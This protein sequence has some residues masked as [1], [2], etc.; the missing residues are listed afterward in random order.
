MSNINLDEMR[1][2]MVYDGIKMAVDLNNCVLYL[3]Y[4]ES[5]SEDW[6]SD[7][8]ILDCKKHREI[9]I[10]YLSGKK[11][12]RD[13]YL[14]SEKAFGRLSNEQNI[15]YIDS[16]YRFSVDTPSANAFLKLSAKKIKQQIK[17]IEE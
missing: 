8:L 13:V 7:W 9:F 6:D 1:A 11:L 16:S 2:V 3:W 10:E 14:K 15:L 4:K 12:L 5:D 17:A